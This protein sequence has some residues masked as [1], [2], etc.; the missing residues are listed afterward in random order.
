MTSG[1]DLLGQSLPY[2]RGNYFFKNNTLV[3]LHK[4]VIGH[5]VEQ[6]FVHNCFHIGHSIKIDPRM[7]LVDTKCL[8]VSL[9]LFCFIKKS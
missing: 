9:F 7:K 3:C 4:V 6:T 2:F 8:L 1:C 5:I